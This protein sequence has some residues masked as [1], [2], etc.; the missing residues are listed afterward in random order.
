MLSH[1]CTWSMHLE[2]VLGTY[3]LGTSSSI[4]RVLTCTLFCHPLPPQTVLGIFE[5]LRQPIIPFFLLCY[6]W[7]L[8][9]FAFCFYIL[10]VS[11]CVYAGCARCSHHAMQAVRV[12]LII[13]S[14]LLSV[15]LR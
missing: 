13:S 11:P 14:R 15:L 9:G 2:R 6:L 12:A 5:L 3:V 8:I 7:I 10:A 1:F 4:H